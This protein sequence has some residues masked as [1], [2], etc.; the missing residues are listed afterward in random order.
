M[1][2]FSGSRRKASTVPCTAPV[3]H[4]LSLFPVLK[5]TPSNLSLPPPCPSARPPAT[6]LFLPN[7]AHPTRWNG[8]E[9]IFCGTT[10]KARPRQETKGGY[11]AFFWRNAVWV[12]RKDGKRAWGAV[13]DGPEKEPC[14]FL[15]GTYVVFSLIS[16]CMYATMK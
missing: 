9:T 5:L 15:L 14:L 16:V 8:W 2:G 1:S 11:F 10:R 6:V 7:A 3:L 13:A 4:W 12:G